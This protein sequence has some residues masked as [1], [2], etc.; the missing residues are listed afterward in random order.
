MKIKFFLVVFLLSSGF[1]AYQYVQRP[2]KKTF[3]PDNSS[4]FLSNALKKAYYPPV[5]A[6]VSSSE[7]KV[8]DQDVEKF[9]KNWEIKG[10]SL[11]IVKDG[12]LVYAKGYGYAHQEKKIPAQPYHLFRIASVS[13]LVTAVGI[14]KLVEKGKLNLSDRVFGEEGILNDSLYLNIADPLAKRIEVKHLLTHTAGWRNQLRRDPMFSP[15]DVARIMGVPSPPPL[16]TTIQF[17]LSQ[18]GY[19]EPGSLY[20]YSNFGYCVL[21]K[22]I[23]KVTGMPYE[24]YM[25]TH[26]LH[27]LGITRMRLSKNK[28][29][30]RH[31]YEV[32]YYTHADAQKNISCY[33]TGDSVSRAYEGT[34]MEGLEAAGGWIAAPIDMLRLLVAIDGFETKK[35]FLSKN[36]IHRMLHPFKADSTGNLRIGWKRINEEKWW[37]TGSLESTGASLTRRNDGIS[38]FFVT[39]TGTW[40]G[41]FLSYEIEGLMKRAVAKIK[42]WP[43]YDLFPV[44]EDRF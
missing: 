2:K 11:A 35:D 13:K 5:P 3:T 27:P 1:I 15:V 8:I 20:D 33:G 19:F 25:Q 10:A 9:I 17:M 24:K 26:I 44:C 38:W 40:R 22:V 42:K 31:P 12:R 32:T 28:Y 6:Y 43:S 36:T 16:S 7:M 23:E 14:M 29:V 21:G 39:N 34:N 30:D 37:R 18:K 4:V 41:P